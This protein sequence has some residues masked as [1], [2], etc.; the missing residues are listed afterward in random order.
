MKPRNVVL[1]S[2]LAVYFLAT[3]P[4]CLA[5]VQ[6]NL[7]FSGHIRSKIT[8]SPQFSV[9]LYPPKRT[10]KAILVTATDD[11]GNFQLTLSAGSYLLEIYLGTDLVYQ[12]IIELK[13]NM[14]CE[15]DLTGDTAKK[16]CPC[17]MLNQGLTPSS[18]R[19]RSRRR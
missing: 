18:R 6:D 9:K 4:L 7:T 13:S 12:D 17:P 10:D 19:R 15:I 14:C 16:N 11:S 5:S 8:P 2:I 3:L 1:S